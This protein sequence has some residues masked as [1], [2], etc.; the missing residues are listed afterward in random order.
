MLRLAYVA[1]LA[2]AFTISLPQ[3]AHADRVTPPPVPSNINV[4]A[5][6]KAFLEGH[7][8]GT[9]DYICLPS[10][11]GFAWTF[12]GPQATLFDG[13]DK[14]VATH[15][16][17]PNPFESGTPRATWQHSKDTST[18]WAV[19]TASSSDPAFVAPGAIPWLLLQVVG[20]QQGPT[21]GDKL[22]GATFIHRLNTSGGV[23][24]ST[25]CTVSTD[26]GKR[27]LVPYTADYFLYR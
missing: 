10:G 15:F 6:K 25:G 9:Q 2:V 22:S 1:A 16:L 3:S 23:A 18:V 4:A 14:Q 26:V 24:P 21:G 20:A 8:I 27:A 13:P 12:F 7:A 5:G 17:S 11:A 19:A